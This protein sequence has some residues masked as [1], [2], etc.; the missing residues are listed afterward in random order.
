MA[1]TVNLDKEKLG[2]FINLGEFFALL[3]FDSSSNNENFGLDEL[4]H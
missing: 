4:Q 2:E 3:D 1:T